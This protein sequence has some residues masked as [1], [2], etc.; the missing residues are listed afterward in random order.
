MTYFPFDWQ[1]CTMVFHSYTYDASEIDL[2][3]AR[4]SKGNEI[5]EMLYD[6]GYSGE[7]N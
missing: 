5:K 2:Q 3:L 7:E 4:D 1:N 6:G